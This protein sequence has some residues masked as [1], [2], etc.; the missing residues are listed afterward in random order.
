MNRGR[1]SVSIWWFRAVVGGTFA[2]ASVAMAPVPGAGQESTGAGEADE[3]SRSESPPGDSEETSAADPDGESGDSG[4]RDSESGGETMPVRTS[5]S[6]GAA[7]GSNGATEEGRVDGSGESAASPGDYCDGFMRRY[8]ESSARKLYR[9]LNGNDYEVRRVDLG[10]SFTAEVRTAEGER[11]ELRFEVGKEND[12]KCA[13]LVA[14][15]REYRRTLVVAMTSSGPIVT[16]QQW[17][18]RSAV[19]NGGDCRPTKTWIAHPDVPADRVEIE[20]FDY[21]GIRVLW[22]IPGDFSESDNSAGDMRETI[23][24]TLSQMER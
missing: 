20:P 5:G 7:G 8:G 21:W 10:D 19:A 6:P 24:Q 9:A 22:R 18:E 15:D 4:D 2:V 16:V 12:E 23:R 17:P 3:A 13:V 1:R 11:S 14:E